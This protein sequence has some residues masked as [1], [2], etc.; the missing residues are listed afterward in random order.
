[1]TA[2]DNIVTIVYTAVDGSVFNYVSDGE[3]FTIK[4]LAQDASTPLTLAATDDSSVFATFVKG[5]PISIVSF[6]HCGLIINVKNIDV[7]C[8]SATSDHA[9]E[10]STGE[11]AEHGDSHSTDSAAAGEGAG[12]YYPEWNYDQNGREWPVLYPNCG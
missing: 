7:E 12:E 5:D 2:K 9:A 11:S 6:V 1:M 4:G 8:P 10:S 3:N